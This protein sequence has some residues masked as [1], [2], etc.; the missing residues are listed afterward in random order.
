MLPMAQT[1]GALMSL[2]WDAAPVGD[3]GSDG[4]S[5][6]R[7]RVMVH[8][9]SAMVRTELPSGHEVIGRAPVIGGAVTWSQPDLGC[10]VLRLGRLQCIHVVADGRTLRR[11]SVVSRVTIVLDDVERR[12]RRVR[13]RGRSHLGRLVA[14]VEALVE[15]D[16]AAR[17]C[18]IVAVSD[19][20]V[21][22][23]VWAQLTGSRCRSIGRRLEVHAS[24]HL[25]PHEHANDD[26]AANGRP[27]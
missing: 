8:R 24:L 6:G 16:S 25:V 21:S 12:A 5:T 11:S 13:A 22:D 26:P 23:K 14:A 10:I 9:S 2:A 20:A 19:P 3:I 18:S 27:V 7:W 15:L 17:R 1:E 4:V